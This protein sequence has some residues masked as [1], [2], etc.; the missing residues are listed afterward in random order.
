MQQCKDKDQNAAAGY[1]GGLA[2]HT[3]VSM[4]SKEILH[5]ATNAAAGSAH[6]FGMD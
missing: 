2:E 5:I 6:V 4:Y 1:A 3:L